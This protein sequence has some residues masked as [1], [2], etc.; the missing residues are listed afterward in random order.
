MQV[1]KL[2]NPGGKTIAQNLIKQAFSVKNED[3]AATFLLN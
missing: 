2:L 1:H 3:D